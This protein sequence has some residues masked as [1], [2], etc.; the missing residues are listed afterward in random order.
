MAVPVYRPTKAQVV[1][2]RKEP[3]CRCR[4]HER[5]E[6][7]LW[8]GKIHW[9]R[10]RQPTAVFFFFFFL[11]IFI[12]LFLALCSLVGA[13]AFSGCSGRGYSLAAV[14]APRRVASFVQHEL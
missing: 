1:L 3:A 8:V 14:E 5:L 4:R 11:N 13:R 2:S 10:A 12:Y 7:Q 6:F 9:R